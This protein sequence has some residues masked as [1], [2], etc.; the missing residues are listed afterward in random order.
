MLKVNIAVMSINVHAV[1]PG[2][3]ARKKW[4]RLSVLGKVLAT[5]RDIFSGSAFQHECHI[6]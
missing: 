2:F 6:G 3:D 1:K 4:N 5:Y